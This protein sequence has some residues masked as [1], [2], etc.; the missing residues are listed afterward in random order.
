MSRVIGWAGP[1]S[2]LLLP[3]SCISKMGHGQSHRIQTQKGLSPLPLATAAPTLC[4]AYAYPCGQILK[5][6]YMGRATV[7]LRER[8]K[9]GDYTP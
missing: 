1:R 3:D 2:N 8:T 4:T 9:P 5:N 7:I 6:T